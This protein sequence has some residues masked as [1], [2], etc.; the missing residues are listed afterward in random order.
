MKDLNLIT[1]Q[2][3]K[4][5]FAETAS[6]HECEKENLYLLDK[7]VS[8]VK[9]D[10][11]ITLSPN[12]S[13]I[14]Q[15][16]GVMEN[17]SHWC[18]S[19]I[20]FEMPNMTESMEKAIKSDLLM[21]L[22]RSLSFYIRKDYFEEFESNL[23]SGT[24]NPRDPRI[25]VILTEDE[26]ESKEWIVIYAYSFGPFDSL[27]Y[28]KSEL[29]ILVMDWEPYMLYG[30]VKKWEN[31]EYFYLGGHDQASYYQ[32]KLSLEAI[33]HINAVDFSHKFIQQFK[34]LAVTE[35][36]V[37][38][39]NLCILNHNFFPALALNPDEANKSSNKNYMTEIAELTRKVNALLITFYRP[40][41]VLGTRNFLGGDN[42]ESPIP[43]FNWYR[44][45]VDRT[46]EE[47]QKIKILGRTIMIGE[48]I[49]LGRNVCVG[50]KDDSGCVWIGYAHFSRGFWKNK[51]GEAIIKWIIKNMDN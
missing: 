40:T 22:I 23:T 43:N 17:L 15:F 36:E 1:K 45:A 8:I 28:F 10:I 19:I 41:L 26:K 50:L 47:W 21:A 27:G 4:L 38:K 46:G 32:T 49:P 9:R 3:F 51:K 29:R 42:L 12:D 7:F 31:G 13:F 18:R 14:V 37:M 44:E 30:D 11:P 39:K 34:G 2:L 48:R 16:E 6:Y 24:I 33:T 20:D 25:K 5:K 35:E